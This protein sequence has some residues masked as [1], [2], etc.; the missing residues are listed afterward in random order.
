MHHALTLDDIVAEIVSHVDSK[1]VLAALA[2]TSRVTSE[3]A[4][5]RL[6]HTINNL[7]VLARCMPSAVWDEIETFTPFELESG[8]RRCGNVPL[9]RYSSQLVSTATVL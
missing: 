1:H 4:L 7:V 9:G 5:N 6:W 8:R 2:R 3:H